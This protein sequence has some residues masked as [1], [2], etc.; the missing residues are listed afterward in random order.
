M[1]RN[2]RVI[3]RPSCWHLRRCVCVSVDGSGRD[4]LRF[5]GDDPSDHRDCLINASENFLMAESNRSQVEYCKLPAAQKSVRLGLGGQPATTPTCMKACVLKLIF[6]R[7]FEL[8][9]ASDAA[10]HRP[11]SRRPK[12]I[13]FRRARISKSPQNAPRVDNRWRESSSRISL[14]QVPCPPI[15]NGARTLVAWTRSTSPTTRWHSEKGSPRDE[16]GTTALLCDCVTVAIYQLDV[17]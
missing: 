15:D 4:C 9:L 16:S 2:N 12:W 17:H 1:C 7:E 11:V 6:C 14:T 5:R 8:G 10:N 13:P 3:Q